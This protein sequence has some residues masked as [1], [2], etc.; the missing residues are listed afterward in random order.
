LDAPARPLQPQEALEVVIAADVIPANSTQ[1]ILALAVSVPAEGEGDSVRVA[2]QQL[3][4]PDIARE[5][6]PQETV[7]MDL[8]TRLRE[9]QSVKRR[10]KRHHDETL[11]L[12]QRLLQLAIKSGRHEG[13]ETR[14]VQGPANEGGIVVRPA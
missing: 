4:D 12:R 14:I 1:R 10:M 7:Q 3:L 2:G 6:I 5:R 13:G 9:A 8:R 11:P